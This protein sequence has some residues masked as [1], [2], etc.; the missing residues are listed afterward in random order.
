MSQEVERGRLSGRGHSEGRTGLVHWGAQ[1]VEG[2]SLLLLHGALGG[3]VYVRC[4]G[5]LVMST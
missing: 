2:K 5:V 3:K 4:Y 1:E